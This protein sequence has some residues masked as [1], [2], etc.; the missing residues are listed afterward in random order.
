MFEH[1]RIMTVDRREN[2]EVKTG[3]ATLTATHVVQ[4]TNLPIWGPLPFDERTRPRC[5]IAMAFRAERATIDGMFIGIDDH[6]SLRMGRDK[7]G[8][9]LV[10][11]GPKFDTGHDGH[12]ALR[13]IELEAWVRRNLA[14]SEVAW[15]WVNEDYDTA[16]RVPYAGE[17]SAAPGLYVATGFNGWGVSNGTAAGTLIAMQ[18]LGKN[19]D[20]ARIYDPERQAPPSFNKGGDTQSLVHTLDDIE[21]GEGKIIPLGQGNVAVHRTHNGELRAFAAACTHK[22]CTVTWNDATGT[23]DCPCHGSIFSA[24]GEVLHGPAVEPLKAKTLP[25]NWKA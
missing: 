4:A 9:L 1:S 7:E 21:R 20:W 25:S 11:L 8:D 5:H 23:W 12:V 22:G 24:D 14:V 16:D 10:A 6:H 13:F 2:W 18:I 19:Q 3:S 15:R 17:L